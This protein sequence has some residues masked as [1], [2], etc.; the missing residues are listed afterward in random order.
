MAE[1]TYISLFTWNYHR[2]VNQQ[3]P[4]TN[5][6]ALK[7]YLRAEKRGPESGVCSMNLSQTWMNDG[8]QT[9]RGQ[10]KGLRPALS[11]DPEQSEGSSKKLLV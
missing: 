1:T 5:E 6:K 10:W 2:I 11:S 7:K 3:Y 4:N 9:R 8:S